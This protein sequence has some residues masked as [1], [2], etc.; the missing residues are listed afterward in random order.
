[1]MCDQ[2]STVSA[3]LMRPLSVSNPSMSSGTFRGR[4]GFR[5]VRLR[6]DRDPAI[7]RGVTRRC[8][9]ELNKNYT[10]FSQ[11]PGEIPL[12]DFLQLSVCPGKGRLAISKRTDNI[13][14]PKRALGAL[15]LRTRSASRMVN[16]HAQTAMVGLKTAKAGSNRI[17]TET[18]SS[19]P[20]PVTSMRNTADGSGSDVL[21]HCLNGECGFEKEVHSDVMTCPDCNLGRFEQK[22]E[23]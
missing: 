16:R 5:R 8:Q 11:F 13:S 12:L 14:R 21:K 2:S 19:H 1:M 23:S 17:S 10:A 6:H 3:S 9:C 15:T 7:S 20:F 4:G 22:P 18:L